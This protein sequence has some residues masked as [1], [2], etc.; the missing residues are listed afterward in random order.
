MSV[1]CHLAHPLPPPKMRAQYSLSLSVFY[2]MFNNSTFPK[3]GE[4]IRS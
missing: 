3:K 1:A 2:N 4:K